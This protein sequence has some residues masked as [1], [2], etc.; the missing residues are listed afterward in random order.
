MQATMNMLAFN[1]EKKCIHLM[2]L[3]WKALKAKM[4]VREELSIHNKAGEV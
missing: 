4:K 2:T 1:L 3:L